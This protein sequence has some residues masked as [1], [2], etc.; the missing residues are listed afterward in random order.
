MH[1]RR[2]EK[3]EGLDVETLAGESREAFRTSGLFKR[4]QRYGSAKENALQFRH[5]LARVGEDGLADDL[6][7]CAN[8]AAFREYFTIG[9]TRLSRICTCKKHLLC[10]LCAIR[11][12]AKALRVYLARVAHLRE[13][14]KALQPFLVTLTVKN[15]DD[16]AERFSHLVQSL[17]AYHKRRH[18]NRGHEVCKASS[19]VWSYEFTNSGKG[20]HPHVHAVWLCHQRPDSFK[21]AE[22]WKAITGDSYIVDV[23]PLDESDPVGAFCE[24]FKYAL[25]FAD[26]ADPDRLHAY[27]TLKGKRLQD[28]FGDLRGLDIEPEDS[29]ELLD[30]LPYIERLYQ[31][32]PGAGYKLTSETSVN[33]QTDDDRML[34]ALVGMGWPDAQI[35][36]FMQA[37]AQR[38]AA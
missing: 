2:P 28:S 20:W 16:L 22:E 3:G 32:I 38:L 4:L 37:R 14:D 31:F 15:G 27:R 24:V 7:N 10:P 35:V 12:G 6:G 33:P 23:R 30:D 13:A 17:R 21:L 19:S 5:Y 1:D 26:L 34:E 8:Y 25:K 18:L 36:A 9:E 29:D 11:R